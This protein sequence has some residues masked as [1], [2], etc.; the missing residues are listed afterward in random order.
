MKLM[1]LIQDNF[2]KIPNNYNDYSGLNFIIG[3]LAMFLLVI[4]TGVIIRTL[5][6]ALVSIN[7]EYAPIFLEARKEISYIKSFVEI[8][9]SPKISEFKNAIDKLEEGSK[10]SGEKHEKIIEISK[11]ILNL[12][13]KK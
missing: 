13:Q 8:T 9:V 4:L 11:E 7:K 3:G 6:K 10:I 5:W 1:F 12:L 2:T